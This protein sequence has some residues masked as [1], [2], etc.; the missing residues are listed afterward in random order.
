MLKAVETTGM[1]RSLIFP[2]TDPEKKKKL[3][4]L[5]NFDVVLTKR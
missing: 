3:L 4:T 2:K 1:G 5:S